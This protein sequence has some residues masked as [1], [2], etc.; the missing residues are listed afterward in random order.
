MT[1]R[2]K[3]ETEDSFLQLCTHFPEMLLG[4]QLCA[5][6]LWSPPL[7]IT[8]EGN[9]GACVQLALSALGPLLS[10]SGHQGISH[11][12]LVLALLNAH[13]C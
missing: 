9:G 3:Q 7:C 5:E 8:Y 13:N 10:L 2:A 4:S 11:L 6:P 1:E 12:L